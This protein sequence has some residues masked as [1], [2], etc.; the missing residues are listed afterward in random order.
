M[1]A[2]NLVI[3]GGIR[4]LAQIKENLS[5]PIVTGETTLVMPV[6]VV[7]DTG[8]V[9]DWLTFA[10]KNDVTC[11]EELKGLIRREYPIHYKQLFDAIIHSNTVGHNASHFHLEQLN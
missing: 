5:P 6:V 10:Y 9:A 3:N 4:T 11:Y 7:A 1:P 2:V 8:R